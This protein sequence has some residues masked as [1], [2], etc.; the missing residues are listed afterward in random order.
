MT[1][2]VLSAEGPSEIARYFDGKPENVTL[3]QALKR[4]PLIQFVFLSL[5]LL[6][7]DRIAI[8]AGGL[9]LR[10]VFPIM[11]T[12]WGFLYLNFEKEITFNK[13]LSVLF[14]CSPPLARYRWQKATLREKASVTPYGFY[15][16][17]LC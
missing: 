8:T 6:G 13:V 4:D 2:S 14:Y 17:S 3:S 5:L 9:T 11:M 7:S 15:S 10:I 1:D 16:I 12:A